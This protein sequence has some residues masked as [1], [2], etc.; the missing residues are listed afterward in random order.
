MQG[1]DVKFGIIMV[2]SIALLM[3]ILL[4]L[5]LRVFKPSKFNGVRV[6]SLQTVCFNI[7]LGLSLACAVYLLI[8]FEANNLILA[9]DRRNGIIFSIVIA[10]LA[11]VIKFATKSHVKN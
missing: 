3:A 5:S 7:V 9:Q 1:E 11:V 10:V 4:P 2:L 6:A 8:F